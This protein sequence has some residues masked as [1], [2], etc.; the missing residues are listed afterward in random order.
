MILQTLKQTKLETATLNAIGAPYIIASAVTP[1]PIVCASPHSG[2][3]YPEALLTRARLT[4]PQ[5]RQSEDAYVDELFSSASDIGISLISARFPR[6]F[7]DVNRAEDELPPGWAGRSRKSTPRADAGLGVIPTHIA[8]DTPIYTLPLPENVRHGRIIKLYRPYHAALKDLLG[9][10]LNLHGQVLLLDCHSMPGSSVMRSR[11]P[12][13][14]LGDNYGKA[15]APETL[16]QI[17]NAFTKR[18]YTVARN[19]PYAGGFVTQT[20]GQPDE[21]LET[22]QIEINRDLYMNAVTLSKTAGFEK[23]QSDIGDIIGELYTWR[24]ALSGLVN[25][26]DIAAE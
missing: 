14:I 6:C 10:S 11:R 3:C 2:R 7:V 19:H 8:Q 24:C 5:L 22:V 21:G 15:C 12:D 17:E 1:G 4:K 13:I 20:Y 26:A 23:L 16:M 18:G 25:G 9:E